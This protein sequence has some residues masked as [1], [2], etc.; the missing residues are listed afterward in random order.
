MRHLCHIGNVFV[1][2]REPASCTNLTSK[3]RA[4]PAIC[5]CKVP[6]KSHRT[7]WDVLCHMLVVHIPFVTKDTERHI[8]SDG[9]DWESCPAA[10]QPERGRLEPRETSG[11]R[12]LSLWACA[13]SRSDAPSRRHVERRVIRAYA[14]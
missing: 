10:Q 4:E 5:P 3:P 8:A 13:S 2:G 1:C 9:F 6:C 14:K 7:R 12:I 11:R